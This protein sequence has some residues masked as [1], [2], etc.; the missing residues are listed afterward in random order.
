MQKIISSLICLILLLTAS[1]AVAFAQSASPSPS[2]SPAPSTE[3]ATPVDTFTLFWPIVAGK[4]K[5]DSMYFLKRAKE[6]VRG[7]FIF[8]K[9]QKAEYKVFLATKRLLEADSL[10]TAG[11]TESASQTLDDVIKNLEEAANLMKDAKSDPAR[12]GVIAETNK[13]LNN[14]NTLLEFLVNKGSEPQTKLKEAKDKTQAL[15]ADLQ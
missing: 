13:K 8:G 14:M 9:P 5:D 11:K 10:I 3:S 6:E 1:P 4:T 15:K 7:F 2:P 12:A